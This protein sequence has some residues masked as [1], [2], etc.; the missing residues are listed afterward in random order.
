M[1]TRVSAQRGRGG[2]RTRQQQ[3]SR[4]E[5]LLTP[6][7]TPARRGFERAS[8]R[9]LVYLHLLPHWVPPLALAALLVAGLSVPGL[10]G[11]LALGV[12]AAFVA[13]LA[14]L[15]WPALNRQGRVLRVAAAVALLALAVF[16][17]V[18]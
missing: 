8:A 5:A 10:A 1:V 3:L 16:Q 12:D 9:P 15:A 11:G 7:A 6:G 2:T 17:A 13:W 4:G 18:R 14:A